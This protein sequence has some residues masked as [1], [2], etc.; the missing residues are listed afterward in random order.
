MDVLHAPYNRGFTTNGLIC[1]GTSD[2][3][4]ETLDVITQLAERSWRRTLPRMVVLMDEAVIIT[5]ASETSLLESAS[6]DVD[7]ILC[8]FE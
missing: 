6:F 7:A 8:S 4:S 2:D 5:A 3:V 1:D